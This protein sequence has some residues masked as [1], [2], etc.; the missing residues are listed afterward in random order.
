MSESDAARCL[1][2]QALVS[3]AYCAACG[4][5]TDTARL[6]LIPF[7]RSSI[8][9]L[10]DVNRGYIYTF[11]HLLTEPGPRIRAY[12]LG[13]RTRMVHPARYFTLALTVLVVLGELFSLQNPLRYYE[14]G[15][16]WLFDQGEFRG[17]AAALPGFFERFDILLLVALIA[18]YAALFIFGF[19]LVRGLGYNFAEVLVFFL[20]SAGQ[21]VIFSFITIAI[22]LLNEQVYRVVLLWLPVGF[23]VWQGYCGKGFFS[24]DGWRAF[25]TVISA[26][27]RILVA[28]ML[29]GPAMALL[30]GLGYLLARGSA[31]DIAITFGL[32]AGN[33][34]LIS[35]IRAVVW[36]MDRR[37]QQ[38]ELLKSQ[39]RRA[40][41]LELA[42]KLTAMLEQDC[43]PAIRPFYENAVREINAGQAP[44]SLKALEHTIKYNQRVAAR[45][46]AE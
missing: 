10:L 13:D 3:G 8:S 37:H 42:E 6:Q 39:A 1:A 26:N 27:F 22:G 17:L 4:Q 32:L 15:I 19:R 36:M 45:R 41:H 28:V 30:T 24:T 12:L 18:I 43:D 29:F 33:I 7:A 20:F 11:V 23:L 35:I 46:R 14:S 38:R 31:K 40:K 16:I 2:C 34:A 5:R 21:F 9:N 44:V 25:T